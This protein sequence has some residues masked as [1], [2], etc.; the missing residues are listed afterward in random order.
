MKLTV[1]GCA[2]SYPGPDSPASCY[3]LEV[4]DPDRD[5]E[6]FRVLLD[7]GNGSLG[8]LQRHL[9]PRDLD[10]VLLSHLHPD[11]CLDLTSMNVFLS[12]HPEGPMESPLP[13]HA[14]TG[15][16]TRL[17]RAY[18]ATEEG[19][20]PDERLE[21]YTFEVWEAD[22]TVRIGP[23]TVTPV[24]VWHPV[25]A[26]GLR[27]EAG[28]A[29]LAYT[30]DTDDCPA[31]DRLAADADLLLAEAA[32]ADGRDE[33][34]GMHLTGRRAG[35]VAGRNGVQRLVLTHIP[36]WNDPHSTARHAG[37]AFD[38]RIELASPGAVLTI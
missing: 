36:A 7:A 1:I 10:A 38:G 6:M 24:P 8:A 27:I 23:L 21:S 22:R 5:N 14:P 31:L 19:P 30:G 4:P 9:D 15:A 20:A 37:E 12:H 18:D 11:H 28:S 29:V 13:V 35:E 25:E 34:R 33:A 17:L 32:F 26:Y 2:G 16:H 3:L